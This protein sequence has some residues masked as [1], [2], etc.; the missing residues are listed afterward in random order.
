MWPKLRGKPLESTL[1]RVSIDP[2]PYPH[3]TNDRH[4][5]Y[6]KPLLSI[7]GDYFGQTGLGYY[8]D[9]NTK[10]LTD[11]EIG[12]FEGKNVKKY[13]ETRHKTIAKIIHDIKIDFMHRNIKCTTIHVLD[14]KMSFM[15]YMIMRGQRKVSDMNDDNR[16]L[17][18][19][20]EEGMS[21]ICPECGKSTELVSRAKYPHDPDIIEDIE[22][23]GDLVEPPMTREWYNEVIK[24]DLT[25]QGMIKGPPSIFM[26]KDHGKCPLSDK[27][28]LIILYSILKH[29]LKVG[30]LTFR[31]I[32]V[33][34]D[35]EEIKNVYEV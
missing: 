18:R 16:Q 35:G 2:Q 11:I 22:R 27:N 4:E 3:D 28:V 12:C 23:D 24:E 19:C 1:I 7:V 34:E 9:Q 20:R 15:D 21:V 8:Y 33:Y 25:R 10:L 31:I 17:I 14:T 6:G 5:I 13:D 32:R 29:D 30:G 26:F